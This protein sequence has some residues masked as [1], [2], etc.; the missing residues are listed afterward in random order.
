MFSTFDVKMVNVVQNAEHRYIECD[1]LSSHE[2]TTS[3]PVYEDIFSDDPL[4]VAKIGR[5]LMTKHDKLKKI[6]NNKPDAPAVSAAASTVN[7]NCNSCV[8]Y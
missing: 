8:G 1:K 5:L 7:T 6:I 3:L 2:M 4:K